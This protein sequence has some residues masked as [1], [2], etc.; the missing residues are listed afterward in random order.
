MKTITL[1]QVMAKKPCKKYPRSRIAKWFPGQ[2]P[3]LRKLFDVALENGV[4][5]CDLIFHFVKYLDKKSSVSFA[6]DCMDE[7]SW[8]LEEIRITRLY[9]IGKAVKEEI[10]AAV[11][12]ARAAECKWQLGRL[13]E[14]M[15]EV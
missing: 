8:S 13:L 5:N 1:D 15:G 12:A 11:D 9:V 10:S 4:S 3:T 7:R 6:C 14:Y 2:R